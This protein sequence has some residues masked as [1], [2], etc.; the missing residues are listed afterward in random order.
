[1]LSQQ[2]AGVGAYHV[3]VAEDGAVLGR[4]NLHFVEDR[5]AE[6]GSFCPLR[7]PLAARAGGPVF[8]LTIEA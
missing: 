7:D 3:L 8:T 5:C 2:Q 1:V 4:F 6:P